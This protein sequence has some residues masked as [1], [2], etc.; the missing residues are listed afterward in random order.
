MRIA[1][2]AP[3]TEHNGKT[4]LAM[5]IGMEMAQSHKKVCM[6]HTKP[7][8]E[9][10]YDYFGFNAFADKTSTPSQI[11]K[12]LKE[13]DMDDDS[14]SD[15]CKTV[16]DNFEVF[17]N[18]STN[19]TNDDMQYMLT[20][21]VNNFPHDHVIVDMDNED[22]NF[23]KS[24]IE[25]CDAVVLCI[26]QNI[27]EAKDFSKIKSEFS[28]IVGD[29][30]MIVVINKYNSSKGTIAEMAK[31]MGIK[32]PNGW[33]VLHEN[34]W[35]T[36]ATNHGKVETLFKLV[37][38]KDSRVSELNGELNKIV[39]NLIKAKTKSDKQKGGGRR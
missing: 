13:G 9:S 33:L 16:T 17:T 3:H 26:S 18:R 31:W 24:I 11:V 6:C 34:P 20:Y 27:T 10:A 12:I 38:K 35:I 21:I 28:E 39:I 14:I 37:S 4:T 32:K 15:Y 29:K 30:P 25:L 23:N 1:V 22:T 7:I 2:V 8:S 36:W 19:F 5:L